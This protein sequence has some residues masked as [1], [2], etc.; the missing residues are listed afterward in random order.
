M[1]KLM[2]KY[3]ELTFI[4][5]ISMNKQISIFSKSS[6]RIVQSLR[7]YSNESKDC[8]GFELNRREEVH[9]HGCKGN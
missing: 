5:G 7:R 3:L 4:Y 2:K 6:E 9:G 8:S 1:I